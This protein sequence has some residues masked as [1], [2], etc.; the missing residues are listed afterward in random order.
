MKPYLSLF[1]EEEMGMLTGMFG[2]KALTYHIESKEE[3]SKL[4]DLARGVIYKKNLY[5]STRPSDIIHRDI[6]NWM[7]DRKIITGRIPI[8]KTEWSDDG[9]ENPNIL[10]RCAKHGDSLFLGESYDNYFIHDY[11]DEI[12]SKFKSISYLGIPY[13]IRS[14]NSAR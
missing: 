1:A 7:S 4:P 13:K 10:V 12:T 9:Y 6:I 5:M 11:K 14:I 2:D 3:F 8:I